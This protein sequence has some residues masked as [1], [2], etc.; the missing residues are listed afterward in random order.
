MEFAQRL[1]STRRG[2]FYVAVAAAL[3]AGVLILVYVNQY[4]DSVRAGGTPV[5]VLVARQAIAKGTPGDLVA[6]KSLFTVSTIRQSQ[7]RDGALSDPASLS[8]KIA[9][10]EIY[11]G[12]QL[13]AAD[14]SASSTSLADSITDHQRIVSIPLDTT[15][16]LIGQLQAGNHVDVYAGFNVIPVRADGSPAD[17]GQARPMLRLIVANVPVVSAGSSSGSSLGTKA[18]RVTLRVQD[19]QAAKLAF[20]SD[21]GKIWLSLRP[22][23]GAKA[24]RPNLVT[25]ETLLLGV[26]S[27]T[28]LRSLGGR[29]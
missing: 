23:S 10:R 15:H 26:P 17:S 14:F 25:V 9:T 2:S 3:L 8:G 13:T 4:R 5:T 21:N 16:G 19:E 6:T 24:T 29:R 18:A 27:V 1:I 20:A 22:T 28:A 12:S 11:E 7:L